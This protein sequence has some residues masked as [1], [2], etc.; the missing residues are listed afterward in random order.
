MCVAAWGHAWGEGR[1]DCV[2]LSFTGWPVAS[3]RLA[4]RWG[5][6]FSARPGPPHP[7]RHF[8]LCRCR[9]ARCGA[10]ARWAAKVPAGR[11]A[12]PQLR[13]RH[14]A[15]RAGQAGLAA[16]PRRWT[17]PS[18]AC[19]AARGATAAP[20]S[21]GSRGISSRPRSRPAPPYQCLSFHGEQASFTR[22]LSARPQLMEG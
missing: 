1:P 15:G 22:Q 3:G 7:Q 8:R 12:R 6:S 14:G 16:G 20:S 17:H 5:Q 9:W 19:C 18:A 10:V 13:W 11:A 2:P 21:Q 4:G